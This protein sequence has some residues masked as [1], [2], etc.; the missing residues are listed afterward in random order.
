M[1]FLISSFTYVL[2]AFH[3]RC[4]IMSASVC[5]SFFLSFAYHN[6]TSNDYEDQKLY[7]EL[8]KIKEDMANGEYYTSDQIKW[9]D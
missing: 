4:S 6:F 5:I 1:S 2:N 9:N 7:D 8:D 3:S